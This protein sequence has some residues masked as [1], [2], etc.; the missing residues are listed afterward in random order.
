[1]RR[2][3]HVPLVPDSSEPVGLVIADG[4]LGDHI[5]RF[6]AFVWGPVPDEAFEDAGVPVAGATKRR[7]PAAVLASC[8]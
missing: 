4:G 7:A 5:P 6:W 8:P 2:A 3:P 1:M